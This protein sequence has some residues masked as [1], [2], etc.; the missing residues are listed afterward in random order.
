M[1]N[2]YKPVERSLKVLCSFTKYQLE[3]GSLS[4]IKEWGGES[5]DNKFKQENLLSQ[6]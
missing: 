5:K 4:E 1:Q 3:Q 6:T 2:G